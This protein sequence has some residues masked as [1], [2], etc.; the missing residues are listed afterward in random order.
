MRLV[1]VHVVKLLH[2]PGII[3]CKCNMGNSFF[4]YGNLFLTK[5]HIVNLL[6]TVHSGASFVILR[7]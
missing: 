7:C 1:L 6:R 3:I 5:D 4:S 2:V